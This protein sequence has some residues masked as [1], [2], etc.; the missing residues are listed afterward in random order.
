MSNFMEVISLTVNKFGALLNC[1]PQ[2]TLSNNEHYAISSDKRSLSNT[3]KEDG[4]W[5]IIKLA[6]D[7]FNSE[8]ET[9]L[10][11]LSELK[12]SDNVISWDHLRT[13][14]AICQSTQKAMEALMSKIAQYY[15][16][17]CLMVEN[18]V[19][20]YN[21]IVKK[22]TAAE[23]EEEKIIDSQMDEHETIEESEQSRILAK[24]CQKLA[25]QVA[26]GIQEMFVF[27]SSFEEEKSD[28]V[29]PDNL[30]TLKITESLV[31][32][33]NCLRFD[34]ILKIIKRLKVHFRSIQNSTE[35]LLANDNSFRYVW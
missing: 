16:T 20:L 24:L 7:N 17:D 11:Q 14:S 25:T 5:S 6:V 31:A 1:A 15:N 3:V 18:L 4:N 34:K 9:F 32:A 12:V 2:S 28:N 26:L 21:K 22:K 8:I 30:F 27:S 19:D 35:A 29:V 13:F 33:K 23:E 10:S